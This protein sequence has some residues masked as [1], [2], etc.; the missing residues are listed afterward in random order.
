MLPANKDDE[1]YY[2]TLPDSRWND[3]HLVMLNRFNNV[4]QIRAN[5]TVSVDEYQKLRVCVVD[6]SSVLVNVLSDGK[7]RYTGPTP[8]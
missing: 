3:G 1:V 4:K 5:R 6:P 2:V 8:D 7:V